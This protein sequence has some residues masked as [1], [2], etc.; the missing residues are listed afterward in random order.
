MAVISK[1]SR[2]ASKKSYKQFENARRI[3]IETPDQKDL[4]GRPM[5]VC[6]GG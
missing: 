5:Y 1:E 3:V 6:V 2:Q 4:L